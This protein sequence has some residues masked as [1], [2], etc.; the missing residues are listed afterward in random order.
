MTPGSLLR[1]RSRRRPASSATPR[2]QIVHV[3]NRWAQV[4]PGAPFQRKVLVRYPNGELVTGYLP[5]EHPALVRHLDRLHAA[6][7]ATA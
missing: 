1:L 2:P 6:H 3:T 5:D 7:G 4:E